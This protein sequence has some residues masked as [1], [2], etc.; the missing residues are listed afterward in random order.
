MI[1]FL[2][3]IKE[4]TTQLANIGETLEESS[5]DYVQSLLEFFESFIQVVLSRDQMPTFDKLSTKLFLEEQ[6]CKKSND[7]TPMK[8]CLLY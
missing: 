5:V 6:S 4:I 7:T 2:K 3:Q 1:D 8:L